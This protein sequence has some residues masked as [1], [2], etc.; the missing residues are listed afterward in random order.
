MCLETEREGEREGGEWNLSFSLSS[1]FTLCQTFLPSLNEVRSFVRSSTFNN[2]GSSSLRP[3][4][5]VCVSLGHIGDCVCTYN[6]LS[7]PPSFSSSPAFQSCLHLVGGEGGPF[8]R[9]RGVEMSPHEVVVRSLLVMMSL[10][11]SYLFVCV[12]AVVVVA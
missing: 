6:V 3:T 1:H 8:P 11:E 5:C 9:S 7:N 10:S 2:G 4:K 12:A